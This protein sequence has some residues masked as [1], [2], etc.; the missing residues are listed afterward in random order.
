MERMSRI[1][2]VGTVACLVTLTLTGCAERDAQRAVQASLTG[3][4]HGVDA[5]DQLVNERWPGA[6][7]EARATVLRE[8]ESDPEMTVEAGMARYEALMAAWNRGLQAMR[9]IRELL[10][11]G[12][13]AVDI[14]IGTGEMPASWSRFCDGIE[15]GIEGLLRFLEVVGVDPPEA[16]S[17]A[18]SYASEAC[19]LAA[20]WIHGMA[21]AED[22]EPSPDGEGGE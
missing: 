22:D 17:G 19:A 5:A 11:V 10:H 16:L 6:A 2:T 18:A 7:E 1:L 9:G 12:Q 21:T 4:A 3:L 15:Q 8:R 13:S 20:P 14:W